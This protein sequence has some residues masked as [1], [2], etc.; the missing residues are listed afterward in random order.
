MSIVRLKYLFHQF[1]HKKATPEETEEFMAML[2][3]NSYN[4]DIQDLLDELWN[5]PS[6]LTPLGIRKAEKIFS[7]I[8]AGSGED[9]QMI[10]PVRSHRGLWLRAAAAVLIICAVSLIFYKNNS[11][12]PA[13]QQLAKQAVNP[14]KPSRRF[15][16]L[17]DGSSVILNENSKLDY[18]GFGKNGRREVFLRGEAYFDIKHDSSHPFIV[19]TG[20]LK[21]TV[22]GTAFNINA[23]PEN[24]EV[25]ITV[26]RG[27][28]K[29]ADNKHAYSIIPNQQVVYN[30]AHSQL[31]MKQVRADAVIE[32]KKEDL[33]FDDVSMADIANQLQE[34]FRV[35]FTYSNENIKNCRFSATFLKSQTLEQI[36]N[37]IAEFNHITYKFQ[38]KGTLLLEG[39]GCSTPNLNDKD[40]GIN[41]TSK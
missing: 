14:D 6:A 12:K 7:R 17:P 15:M 35:S 24:D 25:T 34:R 10:R 26:T 27:K 37:V 32:W 16:N 28:V 9:T 19:H 1:I 31:T 40:T 4:E 39:E 21:V 5:E 38:N 20:E 36:L 8:I 2:R 11:D 41:Y 3:Q 33:Y 30:K 23:S 22:L 18:G 13:I 29:V